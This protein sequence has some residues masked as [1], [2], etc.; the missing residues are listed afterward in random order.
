MGGGAWP[1]LVGGAIC[2]VNSVNERDLSLLTSYAEIIAIVGLQRGIPSKRESSARVD[3]VPALCTHRPS[4]LPIE[5]SGEVFGSRRHGRIIVE[6]CL[7]ER[8]AN[9]F[10][11]RGEHGCASL[12]VPLRSRIDGTCPRSSAQQR[13]PARTAPR[14][15]NKRACPCRPGNGVCACSIAFFHYL[16]RLSATDISALA[17]MKNVAKCDTWCELQNPVNHRVFERKLRPKPLGRGH[18]CLGVTHRCPRQTLVLGRDG[19]TWPWAD[20][21][22]PCAERPAVGL[23]TSRRRWTP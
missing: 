10:Y 3:Y 21:G 9:L 1:F 8:P 23:N 5:W 13:T 2:L 14:K 4:L 17:S 12:V 19:W 7:A 18:A 20:I 22:L 15:L 6:T 11:H 16:K